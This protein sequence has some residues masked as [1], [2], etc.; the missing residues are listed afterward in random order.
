M[1]TYLCSIPTKYRILEQASEFREHRDQL[2]HPSHQKP[3]LLATSPNQVW[4]WDITKQLGPRLRLLPLAGRVHFL[5]PSWSDN[6]YLGF[7]SAVL[8]ATRAA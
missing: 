5:V 1:E 7:Q 3:Q 2:R 4:S 6:C 8:V